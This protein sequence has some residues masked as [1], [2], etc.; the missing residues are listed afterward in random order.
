M[1]TP[2]S[3]LD[4]RRQLRLTDD[5]ASMDGHITGWI[6]D[7]A[8]WVEQ[9]TGHILEARD[10]TEQFSGFG[11]VR[12]RAW[13]VAPTAVPGVAYVTADGS[14]VAIIGARL[15][16]SSRPARV[17]PP[18]GPFYPFRHAE[19]LF[20]VTVRAGYGPHD[21]VPGNVRRAMLVL[22]AAYDQ[23]REGGDMFQAAEA[24]AKSLCRDLR[25]RGL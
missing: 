18:G 1:A 3:I 6:A 11:A 20:T 10:V 8:A 2:V 12:L 4:A 13:P 14:P 15:D 9:Y 25:A 23:D 5:D 16:V 17:L 19:Q 7:A 22:I 24:S 21:R